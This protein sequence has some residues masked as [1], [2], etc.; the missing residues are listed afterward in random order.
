MIRNEAGTDPRVR[1]APTRDWP[2]H[3][4]TSSAGR[5][6]SGPV[7]PRGGWMRDSNV[8]PF[9][10]RAPS[11][12]ELEAY[13]AITRSWSPALRALMFPQYF[14]FAEQS[15]GIARTHEDR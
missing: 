15:A 9:R 8:I 5:L 6:H 4:L 2:A 14:R 13:R 12:R 11:K 7:P 3:P 1:K 10:K